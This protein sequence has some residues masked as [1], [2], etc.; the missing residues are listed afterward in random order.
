VRYALQ[1]FALSA[2]NIT[3]ADLGERFAYW[4]FFPSSSEAS[5]AVGL[6][7]IWG[8]AEVVESAHPE[9]PMGARAYGYFP[10]ASE[11]ILQPQRS[12][13]LGFVDRAPQRSQLPSVY[14]QYHQWNATRDAES[15]AR[16]ALLRPLYMTS[17]LCADFLKSENYF[18]SEQRSQLARSAVDQQ[19]IL[20]S[21]SSKTA[22]ALGQ[23]L[24][25]MGCEAER[26]GL[27]SE[28]NVAFCQRS[29]CYT[30]VLSYDDLA[31]LQA[32]ST[33]VVDMAGNP[34]LLRTVHQHL[35][36]NLSRSISVG[37][38]HRGDLSAQLSDLPGP[39][40]ELFFAP[41]QVK[42]RA[43][44]HG[45]GWIEQQSQPAW[46]AFLRESAAYLA[47]D[48]ARGEAAAANAYQALLANQVPP[49]RGLGFVL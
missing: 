18:A 41:S 35:G 19:I 47:M 16:Y 49:E 5:P 31:R 42:R 37:L 29:H 30:D 6:L 15:E 14:Q 1:H 27:T 22:L 12:S 23:A 25:A 28:R 33:V 17:W 36:A 7:P 4:R 39:K 45:A 32:I 38:S 8:F 11:W 46:N 40:P 21:A 20:L 10:L 2:N 44:Q 43:A 34:E 13:T 3:Y 24:A 9:F 48:L 26:I